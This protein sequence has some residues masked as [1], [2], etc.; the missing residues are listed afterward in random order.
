MILFLSLL[1]IRYNKCLLVVNAFIGNIARANGNRCP[2]RA[3]KSQKRNRFSSVF[4]R[5]VAVLRLL[6]HFSI[7]DIVRMDQPAKSPG[8]HGASGFAHHGM[9]AATTLQNA[10]VLVN[11]HEGCSV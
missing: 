6:R 9:E 5:L 10:T 4:I 7:A 11:I 8:P 1:T 3:T 2:I